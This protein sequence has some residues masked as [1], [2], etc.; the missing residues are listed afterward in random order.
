MAEE[1]LYEQAVVQQASKPGQ[2]IVTTFYLGVPP[3]ELFRHWTQPE[4]LQQW[5]PTEAGVQARKGGT[6]RLSWPSMNWNLRG[7]CKVF[8]PGHRLGFT[9]RG[10]HEPDRPERDVQVA[11]EPVGDIGTQLTVTHRTYTDSKEDQEERNGHIEGWTYFLKRLHDA[12]A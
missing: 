10:D 2:V 8:E 5:W 6:Y 1:K 12:L 9:W 7:T 11:F 4:L 3:G